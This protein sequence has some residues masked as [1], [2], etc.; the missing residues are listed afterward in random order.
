MMNVID[1]HSK[2][3]VWEIVYTKSCLEELCTCCVLFGR[4]WSKWLCD[5]DCGSQAAWL[6]LVA[7]LA[8]ADGRDSCSAF[9][10]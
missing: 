4:T 2:A 9:R 10:L 8:E 3:S 6:R 5:C 7:S 1:T